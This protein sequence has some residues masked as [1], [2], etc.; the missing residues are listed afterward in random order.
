MQS[1][2][3][4]VQIWGGNASDMFSWVFSGPEKRGVSLNPKKRRKK[5]SKKS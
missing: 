4:S 3:I 2:F 1:F 5:S